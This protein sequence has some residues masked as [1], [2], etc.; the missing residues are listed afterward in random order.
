MVESEG[1]MTQTNLNKWYARIQEQA[2]SLGWD[3]VD[4]FLHYTDYE[5][6]TPLW[7]EAIK[8]RC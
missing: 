7:R 5:R 4:P 8:A 2:R 3:A 6:L 1:D